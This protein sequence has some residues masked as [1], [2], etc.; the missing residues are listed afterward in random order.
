MNPFSTPDQAFNVGEFLTN[1]PKKV[2][3]LFKGFFQEQVNEDLLDNHI[4]AISQKDK[5]IMPPKLKNYLVTRY[6]SSFTID[7]ATGEQMPSPSVELI[8]AYTQSQA[9][10]LFLLYESKTPDCF[11][12]AERLHYW[13]DMGPLTP[14]DVY[15]LT[16]D[17]IFDKDLHYNDYLT[18]VDQLT[19]IRP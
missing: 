4:L 1:D 3:I 9:S 10:Y 12:F 17:S 16:I 15:L 14:Y 11:P 2:E 7:L 5:C 6:V 19:I 13:V 8:Q 18:E